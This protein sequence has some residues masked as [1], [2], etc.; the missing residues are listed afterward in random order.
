MSID[1]KKY[2]D[3][4]SKLLKELYPI[5]K[6]NIEELYELKSRSIQCMDELADIDGGLGTSLIKKQDENLEKLMDSIHAFNE[7]ID[8]QI[9]QFQSTFDRLKADIEVLILYCRTEKEGVSALMTLKKQLLFLVILLRKYKIGIR[10]LQLMNNALFTFSEEFG[11]VKAT[12]RGNLAKASTI[13]IE[14]EDKIHWTL[15]EMEQAE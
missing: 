8:R 4:S 12:Y 15:T 14:A 13:V 3:N 11:K 1:F 5:Y 9:N 6:K 7:S 2:L 10:N